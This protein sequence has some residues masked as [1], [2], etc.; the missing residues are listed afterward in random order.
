M[1][2]VRPEA[3]FIKEG[4]QAALL[5][6]LKFDENGKLETTAT[7]EAQS[8]D[9]TVG[10]VDLTGD[11]LTAI[12]TIKDDVATTKSILS[13]TDMNSGI[14]KSIYNAMT[15][16]M[17]NSFWM[18]IYGSVQ[19]IHGVLNGVL[20]AIYNRMTKKGTVSTALSDIS[21]TTT[22]S[23]IDCTNYNAVLI[24]TLITGTGTWNVKLQGKFTEDGTFMDMYDNNGNL[25][26][27]GNL[28]TSAI[29]LFTSVPDY[30]QIVATEITDGATLTVEV[31]PINV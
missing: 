18:P 22:S 2:D 26:S 16:G 21:V 12:N 1:T 28:S 20:N 29:R 23:I 24:S 9:V 14:G 7:L 13:S 15:G 10:D 5:D 17:F 4:T 19:S 31:Q 3:V 6:S 8:V 27:Y 25:L 11:S 30:I